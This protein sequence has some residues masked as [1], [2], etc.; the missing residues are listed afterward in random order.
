MMEIEREIIV[1]FYKKAKKTVIERGFAPEIDWQNGIQFSRITESDFLRE[2]AW[3]VLSSGMRES[4]I[5]SKF[6]AISG[7]FCFWEG[8]RQIVSN[9][10]ECKKHAL[11]VFGH[12]RKIDA[13]IVIAEVVNS[14]GFVSLKER[15]RRDGIKFIQSLPFMGPATSCHLAK[16]IGLYSHTYSKLPRRKY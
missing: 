13:I 7:A 3:V 15:I 4:V 12:R 1:D 11:M 10:R 5:R 16:N 14:Q 6:Q 9:S 8:A 2:A